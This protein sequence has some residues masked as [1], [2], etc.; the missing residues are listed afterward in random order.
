MRDPVVALTPRTTTA[1]VLA[2]AIAVAVACGAR[3]PAGGPAAEGPP[4]SATVVRVVD[5]DTLV[6]HLPAGD[7]TVRLIGID[8]PETKKPGTPVECFG[9]EASAHLEELAPPGT[10]VRLERDVD[11]RDRYGRLLAY[12]FRGPDDLFVN[13][14]MAEDGFAAAYTVPPNVA[15]TDEVLAASRDARRAGRGLWGSCGG[16]HEPARP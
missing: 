3:P 7:E 10:A 16:G 9:A 13:R 8:T 4:G 12:V 2:L 5:G 14:A 15:R 1:A 11:E 6:A